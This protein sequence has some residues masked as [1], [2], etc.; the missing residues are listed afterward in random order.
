VEPHEE[1]RREVLNKYREKP[2]GVK[3]GGGPKKFKTL[4]TL[5]SGKEVKKKKNQ[6]M[7][8]GRK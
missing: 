6:K 5:I 7:E 1:N 8:R 2:R 4:K 3:P